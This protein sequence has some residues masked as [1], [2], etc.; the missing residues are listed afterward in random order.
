MKQFRF[1]RFAI[2]SFAL[3]LFS[4]VLHAQHSYINNNKQFA[5]ELS[6]TYGIPTSVI[7]AV[8]FVESGGGSSKNSKTLNNHFG[9]VGNNTVNQSKYKSFQSV[10]ASYEGFCKLLQRKKYFAKLSGNTNFD[11][12][13]KAIA[14]AGY[15]TQPAEWTRRMFLIYNKF[16]LSNIK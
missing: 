15:S 1:F 14:S 9:I 16:N 7:L 10:K 4:T 13:I 5:Q 8:A 6:E 12:W 2:L 11:V 3:I